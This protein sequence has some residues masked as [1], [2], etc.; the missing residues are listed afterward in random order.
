MHV[1]ACM[2]VRACM[3]SRR[4]LLLYVSEG[5]LPANQLYAVD[6]DAMA[7]APDGAVDWAAYGFRKGAPTPR[8]ATPCLP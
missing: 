8:H 4:Y 1:W 5:C 3:R 2:H 6:M 7:K